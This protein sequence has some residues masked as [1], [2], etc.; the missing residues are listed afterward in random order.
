MNPA[1]YALLIRKVARD[2]GHDLTDLTDDGVIYFYEHTLWGHIHQV[3]TA[4][5][6][7]LAPFMEKIQEWIDWFKKDDEGGGIN[8]FRRTTE[9]RI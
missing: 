4:A 7:I 6:L 3:G 1:K 9:R 8:E 5:I 2:A